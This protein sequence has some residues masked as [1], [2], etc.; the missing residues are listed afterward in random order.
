MIHRV[1]L[2]SLITFSTVQ[3]NYFTLNH[4]F[5]RLS[6]VLIPGNLL[7]VDFSCSIQPSCVKQ[8][9]LG[10]V[11]VCVHCSIK[12][13]YCLI[14]NHYI[15]IPKGSIVLHFSFPL[16]DC[17]CLLSRCWS[18]FCSIF[19]TLT[20]FVTFVILVSTSWPHKT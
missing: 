20:R 5:S 12:T 15:I 2:I 8:Y 10:K 17:K 18:R 16:P 11:L 13:Y 6:H 19:Y 1:E 4:K 14:N 3:Y 7:V 9:L